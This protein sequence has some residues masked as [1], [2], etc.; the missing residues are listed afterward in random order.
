MKISDH[1]AKASEHR[2]YMYA[3][4]LVMNKEMY[5]PDFKL[6]TEKYGR[7]WAAKIWALCKTIN[8]ERMK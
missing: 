3:Y 2:A 1:I 5:M 6:R 4:R 7:E 8:Q